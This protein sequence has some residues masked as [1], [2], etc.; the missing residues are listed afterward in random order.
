MATRTQVQIEMMSGCI[1]E[2]M[3][4]AMY[5][6]RHQRLQLLCGWMSG[7][8]EGARRLFVRTFVD[9]WTA[10]GEPA[11]SLAGLDERLAAAF[12]SRFRHLFDAGAAPAATSDA[13][14]PVGLRAAVQALPAGQRL[15]YLLHELEGFTPARLAEWL[16][17]DP[18][19]CAQL[20]HQARQRLRGSLL[21]A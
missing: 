11:T 2:Q 21:A 7:D 16:D 4:Q 12:A 3:C 20:I 1:H 5:E 18:A 17:L 9:A 14:P 19:Y 8:A 6:Q 13:P 15:L 10:D